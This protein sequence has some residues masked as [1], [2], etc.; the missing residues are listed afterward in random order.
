MLA[1]WKLRDRGLEAFWSGIEEAESA[2]DVLKASSENIRKR[3]LRSAERNILSAIDDID[4]TSGKENE[5]TQTDSIDESKAPRYETQD[6]EGRHASVQGVGLPN[7][8][9]DVRAQD[10]KGDTN[11][12]DDVQREG[13]GASQED[14]QADCKEL[15]SQKT[16]ESECELSRSVFYLTGNGSVDCSE[17]LW[18][19]WL[20]N[21]KDLAPKLWRYRE[22]IIAKAQRLESLMGSMEKLVVSHI[23]LFEKNDSTSSLFTVVG[24]QDW[25]TITAS[26]MEQ[27]MDDST[28]VGLQTLSIKISHLSHPEAEERI[29]DWTGPRDIKKT[30]AGLLADDFLWSRPPFNEHE[31]LSHIFDPLIKSFIC[32]VDSSTGRWERQGSAVQVDLEKLAM[33]MKDSLDDMHTQGV[34]A[35]KIEVIGLVVAGPEGRIYTMRLEARGIYVMRLLSVVYAPRSQYDFSVLA[36]TINTL[37]NVRARLQRTISDITSSEGEALD[38]TRPGFHTPTRVYKA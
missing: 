22:T 28:L 27:L 10:E 24:A 34:G 26:T 25:A 30:L 7:V 6:A 17:A 1:R 13:G 3:S 20:V 32:N 19:P 9:D 12:T 18:T 5:K 29:L 2:S 33:L 11:E 15:L 23:Y 36:S 21:Q 31:L 8:Q 4:D 38:L 37:M 14:A 16:T 35:S